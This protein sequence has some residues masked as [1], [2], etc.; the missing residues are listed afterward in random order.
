MN[1]EPDAAVEAEIRQGLTLL[2]HQ[3][4]NLTT[5]GVTPEQLADATA[6]AIEAGEHLAASQ[7]ETAKWLAR[8]RKAA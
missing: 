1:G 4:V 5:L 8:S 6:E 2:H 7:R 3:V